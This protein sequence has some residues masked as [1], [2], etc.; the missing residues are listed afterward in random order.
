MSIPFGLTDFHPDM[1]RAAQMRA[2]DEAVTAYAKARSEEFAVGQRIANAASPAS[3]DLRQRLA[4][5]GQ[6]LFLAGEVLKAYALVLAGGDL[7]ARSA[8]LLEADEAGA[9]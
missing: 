7:I 5:A 6:E 4:D 2:F 9:I 8:S 1:S 3:D